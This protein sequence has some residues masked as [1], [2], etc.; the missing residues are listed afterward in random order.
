VPRSIT[1]ALVVAAAS[2]IGI[3]F[4]YG[5]AHQSTLSPQAVSAVIPPQRLDRPAPAFHADTIGGKP[6]DLADYAGKPL[7]I[8][9]FASWCPPCRQD[10][11]RIADLARSYH[12]RVRVLGVAGDDTRSGVDRF[13]ARYRWHFPILWDPNYD[14]F[15]TFGIANQPVTFIVDSQGHLRERFL[16]PVDLAEARQTL[17]GLLG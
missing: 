1:L 2:L 13:V 15:T 16:G 8:N 6:V 5:K 4:F 10:A 7:V 17:N 14:L 12:G 9:F 11:P 3:V